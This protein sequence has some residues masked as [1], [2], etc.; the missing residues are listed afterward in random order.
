MRRVSSRVESTDLEKV[1]EEYG[2]QEYTGGICN[3]RDISN[4]VQRGSESR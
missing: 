2:L 4:D 1:D 3:A